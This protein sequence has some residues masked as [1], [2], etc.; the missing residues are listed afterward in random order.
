M[1]LAYTLEL[2]LSQGV[3]LQKIGCIFVAGD[4]AGLVLGGSVQVVGKITETVT[5]ST[6]TG[7]FTKD[8]GNGVERAT[9]Y[10]GKSL[11]EAASG[12]W[13]MAAGA[14]AMDRQQFEVSFKKLTV[15]FA[16]ATATQL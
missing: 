9:K 3:A 8:I 6:S 15:I 4:V 5:G 7:T 14:V 12:T 13:D 10:A 1:D 2:S 16:T 11:G